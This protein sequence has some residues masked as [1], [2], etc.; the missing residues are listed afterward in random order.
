MSSTKLPTTN[1]PTLI[2]HPDVATAMFVAVRSV[3]ERS[4]FAV[5][6]PRD[7]SA[8]GAL[9]E[10][11]PRWLVAKVRFENG[12]MKGTLSCT[13]PEHL[14]HSL[15]DAFTG[16]DPAEPAPARD[17]VL[18]LMGEFSNM[19]CGVWLTHVA[20]R[21]TFTLS[22]PT[23]ETAHAPGDADGV[24]VL[25]AVDDLPVAVD[26]CLEPLPKSDIVFARG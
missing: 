16:R 22:H 23:V 18:D 3:A 13:L 6:E 26:L 7:S 5:A 11:V 4:F 8:F 20:S 14:A 10:T 25:A 19:V 24:R 21:H 17:L 9:A 15:F 12:P 1:W 2:D